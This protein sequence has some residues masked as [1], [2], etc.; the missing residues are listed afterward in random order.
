MVL[1]FAPSCSWS[2]LVASYEYKAGPHIEEILQGDLNFLVRSKLD[3]DVGMVETSIR[4]NDE[5]RWSINIQF[6]DLF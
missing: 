1:W 4:I 5:S 2:T 6:D 3:E